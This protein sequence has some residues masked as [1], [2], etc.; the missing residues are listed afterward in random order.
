M[1]GPPTVS[2]IVPVYN[3]ERYVEE[4]I[5]SIRGQSFRDLEILLLDDGSTDG[6]GEICRR[7]AALDDRIRTYR[8]DNRGLG[9]TRNRGIRL[10]RGR[11]LAFVD[12]DDRI[13]PDFLRDLYQRAV[14]T[15]AD[16]TVG[17][18]APFWD[19]GRV[20][21]GWTPP[22]GTDLVPSE[23][24]ISTFYRDHFFGGAYRSSS[25]DKLYDRGFVDRWGLEFGDNRVIFGED[26]WFQLQALVR[27]PHIAYVSGGRY[28]YRQR[29]GSIMHA[30]RKDYLAR[31]S[32][33]L[34]DYERLIRSVPGYEIGEA[35]CTAL[36]GRAWTDAALDLIRS[37]GDRRSSLRDLEA[38]RED[39]FLMGRLSGLSD[40]KVLRLEARRGRRAFLR[41]T[42]TLFRMGAVDLAARIAWTWYRISCRTEERQR[43]S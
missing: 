24:T 9:P 16:I 27:Y 42:G 11:Y 22:G 5:E 28:L 39:P 6:S 7:H 34:Q 19:D 17:A 25:C 20:G 40:P 8:H 30:P 29:E 14:E 35:V 4:C 43:T 18:M 41:L 33:M 21:P 10:A 38:V 3:V 1:G 12:S 2:V 13:E 32:R 36:A 15:G 23:E 31:E 26:L 37:G